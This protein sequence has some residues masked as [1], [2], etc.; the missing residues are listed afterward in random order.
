MSTACCLC[1]RFYAT[2][3]KWK[4][5]G[6]ANENSSIRRDSRF[7]APFVKIILE[8]HESDSIPNSSV[9]A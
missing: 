9:R 6:N 2:M 8:P 4:T 5:D 3:T 1:F 7:S